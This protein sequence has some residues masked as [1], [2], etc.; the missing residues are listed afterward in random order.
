MVDGR[1]VA[2]QPVLLV[3]RLAE[4]PE[5]KTVE[6]LRHVESIYEEQLLPEQDHAGPR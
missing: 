5:L 6:L 1:V 3:S 4:A 2:L